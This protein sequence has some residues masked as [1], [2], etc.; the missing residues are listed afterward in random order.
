MFCTLFHKP[1]LVE[2][3]RSQMLRLTWALTPS[4][5][6]P[7][8][9]AAGGRTGGEGRDLGSSGAWAEDQTL[10]PI[11]SS[12]RARTIPQKKS[13]RRPSVGRRP[14]VTSPKARESTEEEPGPVTT[15]QIDDAKASCIGVWR[16]SGGVAGR[17]TVIEFSLRCVT[18]S[19]GPSTS[20]LP[21]RAGQAVYNKQG[22]FRISMG[23]ACEVGSSASLGLGEHVAGNEV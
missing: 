11:G 23:R 21:C 13:C 12:S 7:L 15:E 10:H 3:S 14:R 22:T 19:P 4:D 5:F 1:A 18:S 2:G 20:S 9:R 17:P 6:R 8:D 16:C